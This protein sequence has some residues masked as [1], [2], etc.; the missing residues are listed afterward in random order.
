MGKF[1]DLTGERFGGL[2]VIKLVNRAKSGHIRYL[3]LCDCGNKTIVQAGNLKNHHTQS[4]GCFN[5]KMHTKHG[6][7]TRIKKSKVYIIWVNMIQRCTNPHYKQYKDYGG[8]GITICDEWLHSFS[9]FLRD[10]P[11]WKPG[12]TIERNNNELGYFKDNCYW[13][14]RTEQTRNRRNTLY[15]PYKGENRLLIELCEKHN[16]PYKIV[17][18]RI[19]KL[20]WSIEKALTT[21][22]RKYKKYKQG[23]S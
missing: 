10:N 2:V 11:G 21:P 8:R 19:Y 17:W 20:G 14:T 23:E 3:C 9:N 16:M 18:M 13:G 15:V 1:I 4:C 5:K 7:S 22:V 6:H 12:L